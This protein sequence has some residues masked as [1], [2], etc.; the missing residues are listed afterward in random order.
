MS[1]TLPNPGPIIG[2][3]E[4]GEE[5]ILA[6]SGLLTCESRAEGV[7]TLDALWNQTLAA[8]PNINLVVD[9]IVDIVRSGLLYTEEMF[10]NS[11]VDLAMHGFKL[12]VCLVMFSEYHQYGDSGEFTRFI[13]SGRGKSALPVATNDEL[14][15]AT[16][17]ISGRIKHEKSFIDEDDNGTG[18][19]SPY[20]ISSRDAE[21][22]FDLM[23][24]LS[25][26]VAWYYS[27]NAHPILELGDKEFYA[28]E[29]ESLRTSFY[30]GFEQALEMF[31]QSYET[32]SLA[33]LEAQL[34]DID[35]SGL[36]IA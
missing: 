2:L 24:K 34:A 11:N 16:G 1:E 30:Y 14:E 19:F 36:D 13:R 5:T 7:M 27:Q 17:Y 8:S 25:P 3:P 23:P 22:L 12:G 9:S 18:N 15:S 31:V 32:R 26:R 20:S 10:V 21:I 28:S 29:D 4:I 35:T 6:F 33:S